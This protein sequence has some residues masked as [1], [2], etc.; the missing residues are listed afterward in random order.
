MDRRIALTQHNLAA[1]TCVILVEDEVFIRWLIA[2]VLREA[3][4]LVF[5]FAT[6]DDAW[7]YLEEG[8]QVDIVFTDI[9][10]PGKLDGLDLVRLIQLRALPVQVIVTSSHLPHDSSTLTVPFIPKPYDV[11]ATVAELLKLVERQD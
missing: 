7:A 11:E 5:E 1:T 4:V 2:D 10:L 9:R 3:G 6:A 8:G